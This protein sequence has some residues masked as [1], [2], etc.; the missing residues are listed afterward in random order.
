MVKWWVRCRILGLYWVQRVI[1]RGLLCND[2]CKYDKHELPQYLFQSL[3]PGRE[4]SGL[5]L[6][7]ECLKVKVCSIPRALVIFPQTGIQSYRKTDWIWILESLESCLNIWRS[8]LLTVF[9]PDHCPP[10]STLQQQI[11]EGDVE[12]SAYWLIAVVGG[13]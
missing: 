2:P 3:W 7:A 11:V 5:S 4:L 1:V 10:H 8:T 13:W 9:F 6:S 12:S